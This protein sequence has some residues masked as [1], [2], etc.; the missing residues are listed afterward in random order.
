ML[1]LTEKKIIILLGTSTKEITELWKLNGFDKKTTREWLEVG[2]KPIDYD[3]A[4]WLVK[5]KGIT[6]ENFLENYDYDSL[7]EERFNNH[8]MVN[9]NIATIENRGQRFEI[10]DT[11]NLEK[12]FTFDREK[13]SKKI[14]LLK[15]LDKGKKIRTTIAEID[16]MYWG[17]IRF[18]I[19]KENR[20]RTWD[21]TEGCINF[22]ANDINPY[23]TWEVG[24][25]IEINL[26]RLNSEKYTI[27]ALKEK[28]EGIVKLIEKKKKDGQ[29]VNKKLNKQAKLKLKIK[30]QA[31]EIEKLKEELTKEKQSKKQLA[32]EFN[33]LEKKYCEYVEHNTT[34]FFKRS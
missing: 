9:I 13:E 24:D 30:E 16:P 25:L 17:D 1:W 4:E 18:T 15:Q 19:D 33:Q 20:F 10:Q 23:N 34:M 28:D 6:P 26:E 2:L 22:F 29:I 8:E 7:K 11:S 14:E 32:E 27:E 3:F 12:E 31:E 5:K 21:G